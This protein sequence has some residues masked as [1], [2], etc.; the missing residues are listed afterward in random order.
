[1]RDNWEHRFECIHAVPGTRSYHQFIPVSEVEIGV[2]R[3]SS[4][5]NFSLKYN[6][7]QTS[8]DKSYHFKE[9]MYIACVYDGEWWLGLITSL[10]LEEQD[11]TVKFLHPHGPS[12]SFYWPEK[13]D[14][15]EVPLIH[16]LSSVDTLSTQTGRQYTIENSE[17]DNIIKLYFNQQ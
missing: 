11:A 5:E 15:C 8:H 3:C 7:M 14:Y 12:R 17:T 13:D 4:D 9:S 6:F 10:N 16:I 2:K 1:L